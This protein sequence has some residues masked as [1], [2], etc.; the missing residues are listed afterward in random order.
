MLSWVEREL[1]EGCQMVTQEACALYDWEGRGNGEKSLG[2][3]RDGAFVKGKRRGRA[4]AKTYP[5]PLFLAHLLSRNRKVYAEKEK[6]RVGKSFL[7]A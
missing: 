6:E 1:S 5:L 4:P 7:G 3:W 2:G